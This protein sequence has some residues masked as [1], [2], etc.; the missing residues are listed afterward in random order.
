MDT[1]HTF[2][3]CFDRY[4]FVE[5]ANSRDAEDSYNEMHGRHIDGYTISVQVSEWMMMALS[6]DLTNFCNDDTSGPEMPQAHHGALIDPL[7]AVLDH[8]VLAACHLIL[9]TDVTEADLLMAVFVV[10]LLHLYMD[11]L[12]VVIL[13]NI[14]HTLII[15]IHLPFE[16]AA[17]LLV[18]CHDVML[19]LILVMLVI[20]MIAL[21]LRH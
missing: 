16:E 8:P 4:A 19:I 17:L 7:N 15:L 14:I 13:A 10:D 6:E 5:F 20:V 1:T 2:V 9:L 12:A 11:I 21:A 3:S 18:I